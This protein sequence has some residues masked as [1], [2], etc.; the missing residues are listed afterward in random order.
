MPPELIG[1]ANRFSVRPGE[2]IRFMVSTDLPDYDAA[3]V[4]LIHGD[5]NPAGP[6]FKEQLVQTGVNRKYT[7]RKQIAAGGSYVIVA[8]N[9]AL[10]DL[11]SLMLQAWILPTLPAIGR[12][13]GLITKWS[14]TDN[15][16]YGLY[17]GEKGDLVLSLGNGSSVEQV[18]TGKPLRANEWYFVAAT[19]D[20]PRK[21][22]T[23]YQ[24][25]LTSLPN[26]SSNDV[27]D[28][29]VQ[30]QDLC[31]TPAPLLIGAGYYEPIRNH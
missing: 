6:G 5:E 21:K 28:A 30:L 13:Q 27:Y 15:V 1:Y 24:L 2:D 14:T 4:R 18:Q 8:D 16:G 29:Q 3:I 9:P 11:S 26:D 12:S 17:V 20:A 10:A 7:G 23:L 19:Y 25:P 31:R 22:V